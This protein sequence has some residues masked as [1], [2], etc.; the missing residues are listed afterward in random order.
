M[1]EAIASLSKNTQHLV[2]ALKTHHMCFSS[3]SVLC[4]G[5]DVAYQTMNTDKTLTN[6]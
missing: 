2:Y 1:Y 4:H 5:M 3:F 6:T